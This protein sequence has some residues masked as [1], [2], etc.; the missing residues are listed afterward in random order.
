MAQ[1]STRH[2]IIGGGI[3]GC[4]IAYH[5]TRNGEKDV[6]VLEKSALTEGATWHAA[7]LIPHFIGSLNMAKCHA[8]APELYAA[9]E[10]ATGLHGGWHGTGAIRLAV[11]DEQLNFLDEEA[12]DARLRAI[13]AETPLEVATANE[14]Q[15]HADA[16]RHAAL[17][18]AF[19]Q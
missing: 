4:S 17:N 18:L 14:A 16:L 19:H 15:R 9:I 13:V 3:I 10:A 7:G 8:V 12:D 5:L 1:N 6:V 2:L 11:T